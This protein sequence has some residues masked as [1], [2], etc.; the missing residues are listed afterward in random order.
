MEYYIG[1]D[2]NISQH[3]N[4]VIKWSIKLTRMF[5]CNTIN[6]VFEWSKIIFL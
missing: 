2:I 3:I 5:L 4:A 6:A 1:V